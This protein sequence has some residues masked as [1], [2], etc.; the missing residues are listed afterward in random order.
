MSDNK[1]KDQNQSNGKSTSERSENDQKAL[2]QDILTPESK[3]ASTGNQGSGYRGGMQKNLP[4]QNDNE[5]S[6]AKKK[7]TI[8]NE[9]IYDTSDVNQGGGMGG[10]IK[11]TRM[12]GGTPKD[13]N[14]KDEKE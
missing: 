13:K 8:P 12:D 7:H 4:D 9:D 1:S 2:E 3:A 10:Q 11:G 6:G 5:N 14:K